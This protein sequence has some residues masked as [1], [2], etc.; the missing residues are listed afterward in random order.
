MDCYFD[1]WN[2]HKKKIS[3]RTPSLYFKTG[4]VWWVHLGLNI[5]FE[6]NG[7]GDLFMRPVVIIKK[8]NKYSFLA[9]P[10]STSKKISK[11]QVPIGIIDG[12][13]AIANLSQ[14]KNIDSKRL[15]NK[16]CSL[17]YQKFIYIKEKARQINFD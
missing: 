4:E 9:I 2:K 12:R 8:Y 5:G 16:I 14:I 1:E 13:D 10:L 6:M 11:Y 7:K 3:K 17:E 15:I